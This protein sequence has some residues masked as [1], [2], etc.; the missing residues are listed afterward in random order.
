M[1]GLIEDLSM[2]ELADQNLLSGNSLMES[3]ESDDSVKSNEGL[4]EM[5]KKRKKKSTKRS[6]T[7]NNLD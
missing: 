5:K 2:S 3:A 6:R 7:P 4:K 1:P